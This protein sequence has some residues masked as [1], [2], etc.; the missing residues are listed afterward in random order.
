MVRAYKRQSYRLLEATTGSHILDVGC[1]TGDDVLALAEIVDTR[2]RVVGIDNSEVMINEALKKNEK[3]NL[4]VEFYI[5]NGQQFDFVDNSFN[6]CRADRLFQH[7]PDRKQ[8]LSEMIR[9]VRPGGRVVVSDPDFDTRIID[10]PNKTLTRKILAFISDLNRNGWTGRQM[11]R[12]FREIGLTDIVIIPV[13]L[14]FTDYILANQILGISSGV[15]EMQKVGQL[16]VNEA[17]EWLKEL[18]QAE[19]AECFFSSITGFT[20]SGKKPI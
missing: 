7:L 3:L 14:V 9:V 5:T 20:V 13:T 15:E 19:Q 18:E 12:L 8:V 10:A 17:K 4:P 16:S 11:Y 6:G 2:G 1:G